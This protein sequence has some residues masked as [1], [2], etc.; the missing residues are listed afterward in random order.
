LRWRFAA[1]WLDTRVAAQVV[2]LL[3]TIEDPRV[4]RRILTHLGL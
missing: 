2:H 3:A 4:V 1:S